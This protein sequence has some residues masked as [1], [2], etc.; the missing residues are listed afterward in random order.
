MNKLMR[1]LVALARF[2]PSS[3]VA[4]ARLG[5]L[6]LEGHGAPSAAYVTERDVAAAV[7]ARSA[8]GRCRRSSCS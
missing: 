1:E 6:A 5:L 7:E 3:E 4:A 8:P 2:A